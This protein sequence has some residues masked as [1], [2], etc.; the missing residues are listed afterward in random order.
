MPQK[1]FI[2]IIV[3]LIA[4]STKIL[5]EKTKIPPPTENTGTPVVAKIPKEFNHGPSDKSKIA[6]TFDAD[7]TAA[8]K[9]RLTKHQVESWYNREVIKILEENQVKATLFLTG[10][11]VETY[12]DEAQKLAQ[13]PLF[14]IG[15]HSYSHPGFTRPCYLL[16]SISQKEKEAEIDKT[17]TILKNIGIDNKLFRFPGG[18]HNQTDSD[19]VNSRGLSVVNW[20]VASGDA[21][22]RNINAIIKRVV[23]QT[24]NGSIIVFHMHGGPNAPQTAP[25][26]RQIIPKLKERGY[27]FVKVSEL[28]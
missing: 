12:P 28:F 26:L 19:L 20:D 4:S 2:L 9:R 8:M 13:N 7:M 5:V 15:S 3:F 17:Q 21:F 14:E 10:M 25:A 24:K 6:L 11:W 16:R 18:C 22:N 1:I 23:T 27:E